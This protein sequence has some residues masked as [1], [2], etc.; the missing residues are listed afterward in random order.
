MICDTQVTVSGTQCN[1]VQVATPGPQGPPGPNTL[2][3][4]LVAGLG[5]PLL[6]ALGFV[7]DA[8]STTFAS[9]VAGGGANV[10]PVY[11]DGV[12]WRIG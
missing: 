3:P 1:V 9:V 6:G 7:T 11:A 12:V 2:A 5:A 10:V 8:T 4:T